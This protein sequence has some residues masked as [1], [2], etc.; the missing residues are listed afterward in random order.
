MGVVLIILGL[1]LF[2]GLTVKKPG[3]GSYLFLSVSA[4][5][6]SLA[7]AYMYFRL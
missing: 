2:V 4:G 3:I 1:A 5:I 6:V 7:F